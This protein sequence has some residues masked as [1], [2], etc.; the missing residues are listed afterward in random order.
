MLCWN[1]LSFTTCNDLVVSAFCYTEYQLELDVKRV[2]HGHSK[3]DLEP[4]VQLHLQLASIW[5][6]HI[7]YVQLLQHTGWED[8][9]AMAKRF[10]A[11]GM[12]LP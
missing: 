2:L 7:E 3:S 4:G 1:S 12:V 9:H 8:E 5:F 11:G 10:H 6:H